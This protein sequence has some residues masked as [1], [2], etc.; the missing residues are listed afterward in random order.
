MQLIPNIIEECKKRG[1]R[2]VFYGS[3]S[4]VGCRVLK[5]NKT[6]GFAE[7]EE[8][9]MCACSARRRIV[10]SQYM[11]YD[12]QNNYYYLFVSYGSLK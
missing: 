4:G 12:A 5:L 8:M 11:V 10:E 7:E 6:T 2:C 1:S 3:L 9:D